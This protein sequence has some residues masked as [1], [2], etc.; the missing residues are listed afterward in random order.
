MKRKADAK[1]GRPRLSA[2]GTERAAVS[3][4]RELLRAFREELEKRGEANLSRGMQSAVNL[5]LSLT[6]RGTDLAGTGTVPVSLSADVRA[7]LQR[8]ADARGMTLPALIADFCRS[9]A[10]PLIRAV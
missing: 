5:W 3:L 9:Y 7:V 2:E 1:T 6:P 4:P 8:T 10:E